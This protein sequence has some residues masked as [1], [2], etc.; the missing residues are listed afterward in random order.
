MSILL[1]LTTSTTN[2]GLS[3]LVVINS[4]HA[5][6]GYSSFSTKFEIS[7]QRIME[8]DLISQKVLVGR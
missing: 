2:F 3:A 7:D 6:V 4:P 8:T 1:S 5:P